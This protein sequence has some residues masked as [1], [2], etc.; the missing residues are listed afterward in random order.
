M[1]SSSKAPCCIAATTNFLGGVRAE[2]DHYSDV[3]HVPAFTEHQDRDDGVDGAVNII[4]IPDCSPRLIQV[5]LAHLA[6]FVRVNNFRLVAAKLSR[7]LFA[8]PPCYVVGLAR[9]IQHDEQYGLLVQWLQ[10]GAILPP[11]LHRRREV[12]LIANAGIL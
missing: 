5:L 7:I 8:E 11:P 10:L 1:S 3:P 4:D 9:L 12:A 6:G 2:A